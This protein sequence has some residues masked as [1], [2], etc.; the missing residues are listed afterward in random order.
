LYPKKYFGTLLKLNSY[1]SMGII[2]IIE[3]RTEIVRVLETYLDTL[4]TRASVFRCVLGSLDPS[5][6]TEVLLK[7]ALRQ[8]NNPQGLL[9]LRRKI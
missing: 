7:G 4:L 3:S 1:K 6:K 8:E 9:N 5:E 2:I